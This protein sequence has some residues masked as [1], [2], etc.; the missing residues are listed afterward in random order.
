MIDFSTD[1]Q[2]LLRIGKNNISVSSY[3][4]DPPLDRRSRQKLQFIDAGIIE[5]LKGGQ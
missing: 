2:Q 4:K 3:S 1:L 5:V